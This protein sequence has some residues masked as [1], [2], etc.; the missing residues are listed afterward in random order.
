[1]ELVNYYKRFIEFLNLLLDIENKPNF[2]IAKDKSII[3][4]EKM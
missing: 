2:V 4:N 3:Y 1:M